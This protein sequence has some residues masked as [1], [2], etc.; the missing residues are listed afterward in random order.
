MGPARRRLAFPRLANVADSAA[1]PHLTEPRHPPPSNCWPLHCAATLAAPPS[2]PAPC[3]DRLRTRQGM[4]AGCTAPTPLRLS[5][6][7][8]PVAG[9]ARDLFAGSWV[10]AAPPPRQP[11]RPSDAGRLGSALSRRTGS[12]SSVAAGAPRGPVSCCP[13]L[14]S[15]LRIAGLLGGG[16][17]HWPT[18]KSACPV[19]RLPSHAAGHAPVP[20]PRKNRHRY[21]RHAGCSPTAHNRHYA[22]SRPSTA[23]HKWGPPVPGPR[24][25]PPTPPNHPAARFIEHNT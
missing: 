25:L 22:Q 8:A 4:T 6:L 21:G 11:K 20:A 12:D 13:R 18:P 23:P 24:R 5:K 16:A 2:Q 7:A 19:L 3:S 10:L 9:L 1:Q 15:A 17:E 14:V